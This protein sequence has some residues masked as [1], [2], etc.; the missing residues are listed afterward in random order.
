MER[1]NAIHFLLGVGGREN[2]LKEEGERVPGK[3]RRRVSGVKEKNGSKPVL[4]VSV[5]EK[6]NGVGR[7]VALQ[8]AIQL[9]LEGMELG[10][11]RKEALDEGEKKMK[12]GGVVMNPGI[13]EKKTER[14]ECGKRRGGSEEGDE[15][16]EI[17]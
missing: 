12:G 9:G 17:G 15:W 10:V 1:A 5:W 2:G 6:E 14:V 4:W 8:G 7:G 13:V 16:F 11:G 3:R